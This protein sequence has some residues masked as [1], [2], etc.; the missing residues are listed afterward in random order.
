MTSKIV[1]PRELARSDV[2]AAVD[3]LLLEA[4]GEVALGFV[5]ALEETYDL[6][7]RYPKSG[8][9]RYGYELGLP[10]LRSISLKRYPYIVFYR[11]QKDSVDVWRILHGKRDIPLSMQ[12]SENR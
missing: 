12:E 2:E 1:I 11:E 5:D 3:Y 6:I 7:A 9:L 8:S 4:G 10:E